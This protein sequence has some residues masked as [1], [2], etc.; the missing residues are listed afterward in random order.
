M[1]YHIVTLCCIV[2]YYIIPKNY[3]ITCRLIMSWCTLCVIWCSILLYSILP[4]YIYIY[5]YCTILSIPWLIGWSNRVVS[6]FH[7]RAAAE[8]SPKVGCRRPFFFLRVSKRAPS[9]ARHN[10]A[11]RNLQV[12][13]SCRLRSVPELSPT[14]AVW[15]SAF[16]PAQN[17]H[18]SHFQKAKTQDLW[19]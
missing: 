11:T 12:P 5:I 13:G 8:S 18:I 6:R 15:S 7:T 3:K 10:S 14:G 16:K 17:L 19:P 9:T 4:Q 1:L 2:S